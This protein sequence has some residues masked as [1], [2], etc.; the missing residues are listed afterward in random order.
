MTRKR[1][2]TL[3]LAML[4]ILAVSLPVAAVE[5]KKPPVK[6]VRVLDDEFSPVKLTIKHGTE[7]KWA[8]SSH[9]YGSHNVVLNRAPRGIR[10]SKFN[11]KV[12]V[13]HYTFNKVFNTTGT[14]QFVCTIHPGMNMTVVVKH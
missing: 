6:N 10:K 3:G 12:A 11:S 5:A 7:V 2:I 4:G 1:L 9:N 13:R 14:Y 8:W